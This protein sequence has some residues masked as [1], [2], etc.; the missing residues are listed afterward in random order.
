MAMAVD[1]RHHQAPF[2]SM[3][4]DTMRYQQPHFSNPWQSSAASSHGQ[5]YAT[6]MP[7]SSIHQDVKHYPTHA[8]Q[9]SSA[10]S[11]GG[12][13]ASSLATGMLP[14]DPDLMDRSGLHMAQDMNVSHSYGTSY[15]TS[16]APSASTYAP[17]SAPQYSSSYG[18]QMD[19][20][21]SHPSVASTM[22]MAAP[23]EAPR[24][25]QSSLMDYDERLSHVSEAERQGFSDAV[26]ASRG[27]VAMS[28][29][30]ITPRNIY[31]TS[32]SSRSSMDSYGFPS[33]H[34]SHG[35]VSSQS[36]YPYSYAS[37]VSD[38]A[39][40]ADYS[41][42]NEDMPSSRTL[43]RPIGLIGG[44]LP[45][46]PQSMMGQFSSKISSSSQ[47][48][49][50]CK[51]CDK[52]FTRPSSLQTHMYSHTGEKPFACEVGGCGRHF[53]VVS[54]LRRHRKVHRGEGHDH[55]SPSDDE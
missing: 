27:M 23:L 35:S 37:S 47:K 24:Q 41:S 45:P 25:R 26:E 7:S 44:N 10:Y 16:T 9:V 42:T 40:V 55:P 12:L 30:D 20:R 39:S 49:H 31:G 21:P 6:A 38:A 22:L 29:S 18:Y 28:Q 8:P 43:P 52:R 5:V 15:N 46:A 51:I 2:T 36:S 19:R 53:S 48:K 13:G 50:K 14:V 54:N 11:N 33:S 1:T 4:Y 17:T 32:E 3:G 34:S